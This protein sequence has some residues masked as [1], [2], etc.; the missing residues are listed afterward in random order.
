MVQSLRRIKSHISG[1]FASAP[2]EAVRGSY[3]DSL[4]SPPLNPLPTDPHPSKLPSWG[5][6]GGGGVPLCEPMFRLLEWIWV[7]VEGPA[8][9]PPPSPHPSPPS[10]SPHLLPPPLPPPPPLA[11]AVTLF[12]YMLYMYMYIYIYICIY[13]Y[14]YIYVHIYIYIYIVCLCTNPIT[15]HPAD[16]A[17]RH[18]AKAKAPDL[19]SCLPPNIRPGRGGR[20]AALKITVPAKITTSH[21]VRVAESEVVHGFSLTPSCFCRASPKA[22]AEEARHARALACR[23]SVKLTP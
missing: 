2:A 11:G 10:P 3:S 7:C 14:I 21:Y 6:G 13:I 1:K 22:C 17:P 4:Y 12:L 5:A 9:H 15:L 8:S 19:A 16:A 20:R 23:R 18:P